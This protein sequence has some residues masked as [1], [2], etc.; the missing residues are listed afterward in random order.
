MTGPVEHEVMTLA[1][2]YA[3]HAVDDGEVERHLADAPPAVAQEFAAEVTAVRESM[4]RV[5]AA[6]ALEPPA[7]L[8]DRIL[9]AVETPGQVHQLR[10]KRWRTAALAAAAAVVVAAAGVGVGTVLRPTTPAP[11]PS[12]AQ[13]VF[14]A[15]DVRTVSGPIPTGGTATVVFSR[16]RNAGVLVM[17]NVAPP[18]TGTVYQM[19]LL[20]DTGPQSAGTMD[21]AA[22]APSTTAVLPDL[23]DATAL[24]FTVEPGKGSTAPTAPIFAELPLT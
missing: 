20:R 15:P 12:T 3:L 9:A 10:P 18:A 14:A 19:W 16:E 24:A 7:Y 6:T 17:N 11:T 22:V 2:P 5:S 13:Q 4:A 8:R 21:Q 23:G 1:T